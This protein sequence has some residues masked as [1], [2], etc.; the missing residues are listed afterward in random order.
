MSTQNRFS[1]LFPVAFYNDL[2]PDFGVNFSM[3]RCYNFSNDEEMLAE[4]REVSPRIHNYAEFIAEFF[5]LY[6]KS[7]YSGHK[8][9]AAF[10][11]RSAEFYMTLD[12]PKKDEYRK[13]FIELCREHFQI[14]DELHY[15]VPY[16]NAF[17]SAYRFTPKNPKGTFVIFGGFDSYIEEMFGTVLAMKSAG[18]DVVLFD[19]AGQGATLEDYHIPMTHEWEKP[20][21]AVLDYFNLDDVTLIGVSLGGYL[22]IR[23][24]AYDKRIK[25][26]VT[27]DIC[28]DFYETVLNKFPQKARGFIDYLIRHNN[29]FH[30]AIFNAIARKVQKKDL[31]IE[32]GVTQG[33]HVMGTATPYEFLRKCVLFNTREVSPLVTQDV[34]LMAGEKDHYI[35]LH[36][37]YD[38][39]KWLTNAKSV[40]PRL[41]TESETAQNHCQLGNVGL[42]IEVIVDWA[43]KMINS[44]TK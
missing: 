10:Y 38:Q 26:V 21:K 17:M 13:Q 39:Q 40:T 24:A 22:V 20:V 30:K 36:Q 15:L 41:F 6:E 3:N 8:L 2:H 7:L 44:T 33:M 37:F 32:W 42:S 12:N 35:P 25:R 34:L 31:M 16:E 29:K 11:L 1:D 4:M 28:T 18:F 43:E 23:S 9:R 14:G 19:G 5:K 27:D